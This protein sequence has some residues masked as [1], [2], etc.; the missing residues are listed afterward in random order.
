MLRVEEVAVTVRKSPGNGAGAAW[1]MVR[2]LIVAARR[3][4]S[5]NVQARDDHILEGSRG[6]GTVGVAG[7]HAYHSQWGQV[8]VGGGGVWGRHLIMWQ[9][10]TCL[11]TLL[12]LSFTSEPR[13]TTILESGANI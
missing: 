10:G 5:G 2:G 12:C 8:P 11:E 9:H 3:R 4:V 7:G 13:L 6:L 1:S